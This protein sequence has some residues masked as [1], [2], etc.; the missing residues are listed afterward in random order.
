MTA[1]IGVRLS[2]A[3]TIWLATALLHEA[4]PLASGFGHET[5]LRK[6]AELN[7]SLNP[8][9]VS[10]HLST[11]CVASKKA[12]PA[13]LRILTEN[14][15]GSLRL[16]RWGDSFHPTRRT[17]RT[18]PKPSVLPPQ[19]KHLLQSH[20][21]GSS[22]SPERSTPEDPI[23]AI[24][25][26]GK[27]MWKKLGGGEAFIR[28]F[29]ADY[30][31]GYEPERKSKMTLTGFGRASRGTEEKSFARSQ[32]NHFRTTFMEISWFPGRKKAN[33]RR[34]SFLRAISKKHGPA[35][36]CLA[37]PDQGP[38]SHF[39]YLRNPDRSENIRLMSLIFW[40]SMIFVYLMED[41]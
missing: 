12:N 16:F 5:I 3:D 18:G 23:L 21:A 19:Y 9:S 31:P 14:P 39:L 30:F 34:A 24:T 6:V 40:D 25:G 32:E 28:G 20:A 27:E 1:T 8:R 4:Q 11:H 37:E 41:H 2:I 13:T 36:H 35:S 33:P 29:R 26:V 10:T 7:P 15:D 38:A 17:G 22:N